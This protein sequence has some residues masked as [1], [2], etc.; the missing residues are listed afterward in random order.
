MCGYIDIYLK[1]YDL[2]LYLQIHKA[3][4]I[5]YIKIVPRSL[6]WKTGQIV[7]STTKIRKLR[8]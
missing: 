4:H 1:A 7:L 3:G 5:S 6:A 8:T 2:I